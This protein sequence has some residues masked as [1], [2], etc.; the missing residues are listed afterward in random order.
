MD[1]VMEIMALEATLKFAVIYDMRIVKM[2]QFVALF[3]NISRMYFI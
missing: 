3:S 1:F 2:K